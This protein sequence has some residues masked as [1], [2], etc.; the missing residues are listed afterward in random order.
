MVTGFKDMMEKILPF[1]DKYPLSFMQDLYRSCMKVIGSKSQDLADFK[2]IVKL[3]KNKTHLTEI[4]LEEIRS[5]K[6]RMNKSR[7]QLSDNS[8]PT[9]LAS[10]ANPCATKISLNHESKK[11]YSTLNNTFAKKKEENA[12]WDAYLV[13]RGTLSCSETVS[14]NE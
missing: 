12:R 4:G 7:I 2:L 9:R 3:I 11:Y 8:Q 1:F 14:F 10:P 13:G 5:I 6:S